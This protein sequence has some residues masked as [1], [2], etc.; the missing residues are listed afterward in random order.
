MSANSRRQEKPITRAS[1]G[2]ADEPSQNEKLDI[3][4]EDGESSKPWNLVEAVRVDGKW[5]D[6]QRKQYC[7]T[8]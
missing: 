2:A 6:V 3:W 4:F 5:H 8:S 1:K 7:S